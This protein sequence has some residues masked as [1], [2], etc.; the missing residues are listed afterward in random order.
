MQKYKYYVMFKSWEENHDCTFFSCVFR[1]LDSLPH[2]SFVK[3]TISKVQNTGYCVSIGPLQHIECRTRNE[4][5]NVIVS[6]LIILYW[7]SYV[8]PQ[9]VILFFIFPN[10]LFLEWY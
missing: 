6:F 9:V 7:L 8:T 2:V 4:E 3:K 5:K 1:T 10:V